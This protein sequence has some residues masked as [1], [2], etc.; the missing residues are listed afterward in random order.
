MLDYSVLS[1]II[2]FFAGTYHIEDI[3]QASRGSQNVTFDNI[4]SFFIDGC[5]VGSCI[6]I[7]PNTVDQKGNIPHF[8]KC[9]QSAI[10]LLDGYSLTKSG[11][12]AVFQ[13]R[14]QIKWT[15]LEYMRGTEGHWY[16]RIWREVCL[17]SQTP[18]RALTV[19]HRSHA[20]LV[21]RWD[22]RKYHVHLELSYHFVSQH[23]LVSKSL[24]G[25]G[26][27]RVGRCII[28]FTGS[29]CGHLVQN[30][31]T[32]VIHH[33]HEVSWGHSRQPAKKRIET[34]KWNSLSA[35]V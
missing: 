7:C 9:S 34:W 23:F 5:V 21:Y 2:C 3:K 4:V 27:I 17:R 28:A 12:I 11:G 29:S 10:C 19:C 22:L 16:R 26:P 18:A 31:T 1:Q 13:G 33:I 24:C 25:G 32:L 6:K 15:S 30:R 20:L 35:K 8:S 14:K